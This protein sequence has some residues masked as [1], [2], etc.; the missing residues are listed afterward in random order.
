MKQNYFLQ[1]KDIILTTI[2][3]E[4]LEILRIWRNEEHIRE[5]FLDNKEISESQQMDWFIKYMTK[6]ND[7]MFIISYKEIKVGA[8]ALYGIE[9]N[10]TAEFGRF[11][12][13]EDAAK[14]KGIAKE[15]MKMIC[16][17]GFKTFNL[18]NITLE[19]FTNNDRAIKIY[20]ELGFQI[21]DIIQ[22]NN[23]SLYEMV[24]YA[25]N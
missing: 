10:K 1:T 25:T 14:G 12:I 19:V 7:Y 2:I 13:G 9:E 15:A 4:D 16:N 21:K 6:E 11:M 8:L 17:W 3:E 18:K 20:K 5:M 22:K 23:K 24:L